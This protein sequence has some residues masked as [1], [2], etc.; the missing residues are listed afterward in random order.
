M[1]DFR[2][3]PTENIPSAARGIN[4]FR[5]MGYTFHSAVGD[6]I[7]NSISHGKAENIYIKLDY[8]AEDAEEIRNLL[9]SH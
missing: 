1:T 2:K 5:D 7:D 8:A 6:I 4:A 9:L 3:N